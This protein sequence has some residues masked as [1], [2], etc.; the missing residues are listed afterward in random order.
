[1]GGYFQAPSPA[2]MRG[3][4]APHAGLPWWRRRVARCSGLAP[5]SAS[6]LAPHTL[7][8]TGLVVRIFRL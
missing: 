1:M 2:T 3:H 4:D 6:T 5:V 7:H 8:D